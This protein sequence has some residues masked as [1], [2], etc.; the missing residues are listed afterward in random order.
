[1]CCYNSQWALNETILILIFLS[2]VW[3]DSYIYDVAERGLTPDHPFFI[4]TATFFYSTQSKDQS[5]ISLFRNPLKYDHS[6]NTTRFWWA[7][8]GRTNGSTISIYLS[9]VCVK[10]QVLI[11]YI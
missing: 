11:L 9:G 4:I 10:L 1:M 3:T 6:F 5:V 2:S 7:V 8:G